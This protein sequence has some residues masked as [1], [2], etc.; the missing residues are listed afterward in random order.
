MYLA[1]HD[2]FAFETNDPAFMEG[3]SYGT[4]DPWQVQLPI[5]KRYLSMFPHKNRCYIDIGAHIGTTAAVYSRLFSKVHAYEPFSDNYQLLVRNV[6]RNHL[7]NCTVHNIGLYSQECNGTM[8]LHSG[9]NSG[10]YYFAPSESGNVHCID[11]DSQDHDC[12]DFIKID[13]EGSE[14]HVLKGAEKTLRRWKPLIQ[15]ERNGLSETLYSIRF[16]DTVEYLESLGY[17]AFDTSDPYNMFMYCPDVE[18]RIFCFWTGENPMSEN[19]RNCLASMKEISGCEI[20]LVT[21]ETLPK[22]IIPAQPLH[23]AYAYLSETHKADYLRTYFMHFYGGGYSDVKIQSGSWKK[24]FD[25]FRESPAYISGYKEISANH[26]ACESVKDKWEELVG[27]CA[28]IC[29]PNTPFTQT[30]YSRMMQLLNTKLDDLRKHPSRRVDDCREACT[31]YPIEWN[32]MLGRIFHKVCYEFRD[33]ID[34][35]VPIVIFYNY[36]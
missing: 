21:P 17:M 8:Q 34:T 15:F 7:T 30:W 3:I 23:L 5:V 36:K 35:H 2:S 13:T 9:N 28:F 10:C 32:E 27:V 18:Q 33:K 25:L 26:V 16:R 24:A 6:E 20:V 4:A 14:L 1:K 31:G 11:L 22:Y 29:K 19:R 12:V